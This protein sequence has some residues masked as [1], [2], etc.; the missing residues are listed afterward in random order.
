M[1]ACTCGTV[2]HT[3]DC[4]IHSFIHF[5]SIQFNSIQF[6]S[7]QFNSI[8]FNSIQFNSI[9]FNSFIQ[10]N[11]IQFNS[12]QFNSIQ[13]N[14]IQFNSIQFNSIHFI[15]FHFISFHFISFHFISFHF[16]S[17]HFISFHF[18]SFHFIHS[19]ASLGCEPRRLLARKRVT[20]VRREC[21]RAVRA[22]HA[23]GVVWCGACGRRPFFF[24]ARGELC[25]S[26][27]PRRGVDTPHPA[28]LYNAV[29]KGTER[30]T[31]R[32]RVGGRWKVEARQNGT[33][34]RASGVCSG[35][36]ECC[37]PCT[38]R[39]RA[40]A[41]HVPLAHAV[42]RCAALC[43]AALRVTPRR[44]C[45]VAHASLGCEPRRLLARKRVTR[46]RRECVRA[47]RAEHALSVVWCDA[48]GRRPFFFFRAWGTLR[49]GCPSARRGHTTPQ[50]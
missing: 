28:A 50:P 45:R 35:V 26:V 15:S 3:V 36:T 48:C 7:I 12:I 49:V 6:N 47:V 37:V 2:L 43:C 34:A 40:C 1:C 32:R 8:Q 20:R 9:Q 41:A 22:E 19:H 27:V 33:W 16:I 25:A 24:F 42:L 46:V 11:S 30:R 17:F 18:I 23:L 31:P 44:A 21:V 38:R 14:S 4:V 29:Q 13:F 10:F 39:T 5:N